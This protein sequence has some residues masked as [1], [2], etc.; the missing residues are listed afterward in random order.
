VHTNQALKLTVLAWE[1]FNIALRGF[2]LKENIRLVTQ[3][4]LCKIKVGHAAA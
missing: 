3:F 4:V 1:Q 2:V